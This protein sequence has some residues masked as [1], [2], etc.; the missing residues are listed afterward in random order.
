MRS[1]VLSV[2]AAVLLLVSGCAGGGSEQDDLLRAHGLEGA[3]TQ[4]VVEQLD[5]THEDRDAGLA[6]S[7]TYD[8]VVLD[9]GTAETTLPMPEDRFYLAVAPYATTTH[10]CFFHSLAT[11][12]GELVDEPVEVTITDSDGAVLVDES[13]TTHSNGFVG[14][15]LPEGV[16]GTGQVRP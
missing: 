4:E 8:E 2:S 11:C 15:W 16:E 6:G 1:A 7:V 10:E 3:S 9:D 14:Y 12:H 5:R 13:A